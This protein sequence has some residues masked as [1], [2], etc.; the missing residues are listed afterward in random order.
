MPITPPVIMEQCALELLNMKNPLESAERAREIWRILVEWAKKR[1]SLSNWLDS[2]GGKKD[3]HQ[4]VKR[5][6]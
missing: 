4:V 1:Y 2:I 3:D 6:D 5:S